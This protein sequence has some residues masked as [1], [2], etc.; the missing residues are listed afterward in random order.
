MFSPK[1]EFRSLCRHEKYY[2]NGGDLHFVVEHVTFRVHRYFFE[3]ESPFF[4]GKLAAP[5]SPGA[6]LQGTEDS[7]AIVLSDVKAADFAMF[8]WVFYN[9]VY[10]L[11][12]AT[13]EEWCSILHLA[14]DWEFNEVKNLCVRELEKL[15]MPDVDRVVIYHKYHVDR[16]LLIP[17]Y[18][19]LCAREEPLTLPEGMKLGMETTL[20]ISRARE[21]ARALPRPDSGARSPTR[22]EVEPVV[23]TD[24]IK[25]VFNIEPAKSADGTT[26]PTPP[27]NGVNGANGTHGTNGTAT[28]GTNGT[29][30]GRPLTPNLITIA[31]DVATSSTS[32]NG[33]GSEATK[34]SKN[35]ESKSDKSDDTSKT[36]DGASAQASGSS[37]STPNPANESGAGKKGGAG[38]KNNRGRK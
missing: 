6:S 5:A 12:D 4:R 30:L 23:M 3:R 29:T 10:S 9:P 1:S 31:T 18:A 15:A 38:E 26:T 32:S 28:N 36:T 27:T 33:A 13:V 21:C 37:V 22:A 24:I 19:A 20:M 2:L 8:L 34:G 17:R 11:Y 7:N 14:A 35:G 16:N 25:D